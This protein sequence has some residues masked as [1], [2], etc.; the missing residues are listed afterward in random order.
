MARK[1]TKI[2]T[3]L[4]ALMILLAF[5]A[6]IEEEDEENSSNNETSYNT[7]S[8]SSSSTL[9]S[10]GN[11]GFKALYIADSTYTVSFTCVAGY[12]YYIY[13]ADSDSNYKSVLSNNGFSPLADGYFGL[14]KGPD[15]YWRTP[16]DVSV[17]LSETH[18]TADKS[19]TWSIEIEKYPTSSSGYVGLR[20]ATNYTGDGSTT[21][22]GNT[23]SSTT[24]KNWTY[25]GMQS[26]NSYHVHRFYA[27]PYTSYT[28]WW[29]DSES[30]L[31][32]SSIGVCDVTVSAYYSTNS[33]TTSGTYLFT[34]A[35]SGYSTGKTIS[36]STTG[37]YIY[38]KVL[39]RYSTSLGIYGIYVRDSGGNDVKT[40]YMTFL[41]ES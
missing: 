4:L 22:G 2:A 12:T 14:V 39:P 41:S 15:G 35:D 34:N 23:S 7:I 26:G 3:I 19:G 17:N 25:W 27:S 29:N 33:S 20:I 6:C 40:T 11:T 8:V 30:T 18:F 1:L 36:S 13:W 31:P 5:T 21:V 16:S 32:S 10:V 38:L 9:K 37:R 28:I 24:T